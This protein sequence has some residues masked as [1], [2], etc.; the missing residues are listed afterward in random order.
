MMI[1]NHYPIVFGHPWSPLIALGIVVGGG[2]VRHYLQHGRRRHARLDGE[3][4]DPGG[5][6]CC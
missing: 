2:L 4:L 5:R 1:S 6:R 3:G